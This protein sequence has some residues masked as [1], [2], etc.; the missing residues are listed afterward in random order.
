LPDDVQYSFNQYSKNGWRGNF[1]GQTLG[2]RAGG[3]YKNIPINE[4]TKLPTITILVFK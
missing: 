2:T 4:G 1:K 3:E